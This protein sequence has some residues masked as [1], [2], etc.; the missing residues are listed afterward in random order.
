MDMRHYFIT[1]V[2]AGIGLALAKQLL[3]RGHKV[4]GVA[5]QAPNKTLT[6]KHKQA[7]FFP[8]TADVSDAEAML[9]A[10]N[11]AEKQL[12]AIDVAILNAGV[13]IP[14]FAS[15]GR[16]DCTLTASVGDFRQQ[17]EINYLG[18]IHALLPLLPRMAKQK[19]GHIVLMA[20]VAAWRGLP[21]AAGYAPSKAA[22][23]ALAESLVF[24]C[25]PHGIKVQV[26]CPGF[27]STRATAV[28][29]FAMPMLMTPEA[30][31]TAIIKGMARK[32]FMIQFPFPFTL[33]LQILRLL[34]YAW[35]FWLVSRITRQG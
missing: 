30:A 13:Y 2:S 25:R 24:A 28:N 8:M 3:A 17:I 22:S 5:R 20:S 35:Y 15:D 23:L 19:S 29:Q 11:K 32:S 7:Q 10:I 33:A 12:G 4:S 31:A 16:E 27:V 18:Q 9:S 34:P 26:V 21:L 1:G 6:N 14:Q